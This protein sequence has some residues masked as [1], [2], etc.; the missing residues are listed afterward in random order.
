MG[1]SGA[2][3]LTKM[4]NQ[5]A[6]AGLVQ[7]LSEAIHFAESADLD[8]ADVMAV[9]SKGAAQSWQMENRWETM[10]KSSVRFWLCRRLDAQGPGDLSGRSPAQWRAITSRRA[11]RPVLWRTAAKR[12]QS[13]RYIQPDHTV[14][15]W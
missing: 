1:P 13:P 5:I 8:V 11:G 10:N 9:I 2:G 3:Q 6:I 15:A 7:S 12:R 14:G 4:V